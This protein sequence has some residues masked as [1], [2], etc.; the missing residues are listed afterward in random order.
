MVHIA[1]TLQNVLLCGIFHFAK[2]DQIGN[3]NCTFPDLVKIENCILSI[4]LCETLYQLLQK[5]SHASCI[6]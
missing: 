1:N 2:V 5:Y 3:L 4:K 6:N